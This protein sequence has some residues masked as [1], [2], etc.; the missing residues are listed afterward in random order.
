MLCLIF[1]LKPLWGCHFFFKCFLFGFLLL[2]MISG[3]RGNVLVAMGRGG[4]PVVFWVLAGFM[5]YPL[6]CLLSGGLMAQ[7][8]KVHSH[9]NSWS[10]LTGIDSMPPPLSWALEHLWI[11]AASSTQP[12]LGWPPYRSSHSLFFLHLSHLF[13]S[14]LWAHKDFW[15]SFM[16]RASWGDS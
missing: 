11:S 5:R 16:T 14:S 6:P 8:A 9:W 1:N 15:T 2:K 12:R 4:P 7:V 3:C 10:V 13:C